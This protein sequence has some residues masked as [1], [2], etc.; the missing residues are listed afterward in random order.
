[1]LHS[2]MGLLSALTC[3]TSMVVSV[4][5]VSVTDKE[6]PVINC[7]AFQ[8]SVQLNHLQM[9]STGYIHMHA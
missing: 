9:V 3:Q 6:I 2:V 7:V 4:L 1:M 8:V 5:L